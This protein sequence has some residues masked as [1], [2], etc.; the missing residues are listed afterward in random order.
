[1]KRDEVIATLRAHERE[2]N[3]AGIASLSLFGSVARGEDREDSDV[4]VVVRLTEE[5]SQ[6]G[7][8][9]FGRLEA[10]RDRLTAIVGRPV[11]VVAEPVRKD[12]LR[13]AIET[14]RAVAF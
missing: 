3:A 9:Y 14:E 12:Q 6:G 4:D 13:R 10:L 8:A 1:M 7:F 2:L 11:D 5:A